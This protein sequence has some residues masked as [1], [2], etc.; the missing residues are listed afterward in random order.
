LPTPKASDTARAHFSKALRLS[1]AEALKG[2]GFLLTT[3]S[4]ICDL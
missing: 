4:Q 3:R 1:S 2:V